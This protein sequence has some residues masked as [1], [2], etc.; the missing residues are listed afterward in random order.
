M[1]PL[2][3]ALT[4]D[5]PPFLTWKHR[6]RK[7]RD[8]ARL[9]VSWASCSNERVRRVGKRLETLAWLCR[10]AVLHNLKLDKLVMVLA[11]A[12]GVGANA[13]LYAMGETKPDTLG[14]GACTAISFRTGMRCQHNLS[15]RPG[16]HPQLLHHRRVS[17]A[18]LA[19]HIDTHHSICLECLCWHL[20]G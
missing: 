16:S 9:Q 8:Q 20:S 3:P 13:D 18:K 2:Q 10:R 17:T 11:N 12:S 19:S 15:C 4:D 1:R 5:I 7:V 6:E 14:G